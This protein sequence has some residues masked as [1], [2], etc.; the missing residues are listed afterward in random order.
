MTSDHNSSNSPPIFS[1][2]WWAMYKDDKDR[3]IDYFRYTE[4]KEVQCTCIITRKNGRWSHHR[5]FEWVSSR[6]RDDKEVVLQAVQK[7]GLL[8]EFASSRLRNDRS[9]VIEA[10][11]NSGDAIKF[12]GSTFRDE[13]DVILLAYKTYKNAFEYA[14]KRVKD[15]TDLFISLVSKKGEELKWASERLKASKSVVSKAVSN[16]GSSLQHANEKLRDDKEVV[17]LAVR[18][19][20]A[21]LRYASLRLRRDK[22]VVLEATTYPGNEKF[23]GSSIQYASTKLRGDSHFLFQILSILK[24]DTT[25]GSSILVFKYASKELKAH[26][27]FV[28]EAVDKLPSSFGFFPKFYGDKEILKVAVASDPT[29]FRYAP[30]KFRLDPG[31]I[32]ALLRKVKFG[33]SINPY[34]EFF[35]PFGDRL[36]RLNGSLK[37]ADSDLLRPMMSRP[38]QRNKNKRTKISMEPINA[39]RW[40]Q[41]QWERVWLVSVVFKGSNEWLGCPGIHESIVS[42]AGLDKTIKLATEVKTCESVINRLIELD[43]DYKLRKIQHLKC[44][45]SDDDSD[46]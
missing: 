42:F 38:M 28:Q 19:N 26:R 39:S 5:P 46:S 40:I 7:D 35:E 23:P 21:S 14:S 11:Q 44:E 10:L 33:K 9:V 16:N 43:L 25:D 36:L 6:L 18:E 20:A 4:C 37:M 2:R 3:V 30:T 34:R 27:P 31:V 22:E 29:A 13:S 32:H 8:L 17:L 45:D 41:D 1:R 15:S 12:A 24:K